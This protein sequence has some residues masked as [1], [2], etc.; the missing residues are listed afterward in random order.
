[1]GLAASSSSTSPLAWSFGPILGV[2]VAETS[3]PLISKATENSLRRPIEASQSPLN[4]REV[5]RFSGP[6]PK[7]G[8][9]RNSNR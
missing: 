6:L 3:F 8:D 5:A 7:R 9:A 1:M 4:L 2:I